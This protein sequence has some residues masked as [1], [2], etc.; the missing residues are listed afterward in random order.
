MQDVANFILGKD[1]A[2]NRYFANALNDPEALV[3]MA[4]YITKGPEVF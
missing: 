1:D 4:W 2:G 3:K